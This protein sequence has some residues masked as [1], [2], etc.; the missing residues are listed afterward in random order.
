LLNLFKEFSELIY[1]SNIREIIVVVETMEIP[2][3]FKED[4][5]DTDPKALGVYLALLFSTLHA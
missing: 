2:S 4:W 5:I 3:W 1:I